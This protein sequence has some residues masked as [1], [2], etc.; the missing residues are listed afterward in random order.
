MADEGPD[1]DEAIHSFMDLTNATA[2]V[3]SLEYSYADFKFMFAAS[4]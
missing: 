4:S 2:A 3:V 1:R